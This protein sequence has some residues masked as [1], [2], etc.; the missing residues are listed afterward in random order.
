MRQRYMELIGAEGCYF[1]SLIRAA[2][3]QILCRID[4]VNAY[5]IAVSNLWMGK[6]CYLF[7]PA[8]ILEHLTG[9]TWTVRK[10]PKDYKIKKGDVVILRYE[11]KTTS[12]TYTHFVL[13]GEHGEVVYDPYGESRTVGEG[14]LMDMRVFTQ[15]W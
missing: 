3:L 15:I 8:R 9:L 6:D 10:E 2:E 14:Q 5:E 11:R 7:K 1:L 13:A 4:A 12:R